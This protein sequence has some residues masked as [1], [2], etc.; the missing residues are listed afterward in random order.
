[1]STIKEEYEALRERRRKVMD[2]L[3]ILEEN[4][5]VKR[6]SELQK[7]NEELGDQQIR[8]YKDMKEE[9]YDSCSHILIYSKITDHWFKFPE[10][11][12]LGCIKCG[13]D[14]R[15]CDMYSSSFS[16]FPIDWMNQNPDIIDLEE[17]K[18]MYFYFLKENSKFTG[19][20]TGISCDIS[21]AQSIYSK[22]KQAHPNIDDETAIKYFEYALDKIRS[23]K[24]NDERKI[25]RAKRLSLTPNFKRWNAKDVHYH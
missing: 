5:P 12:S 4:E 10:H 6:Y 18:I 15:A 17:Y 22:I 11:K 25:S 23:T 13:L 2:D 14:S 19:T 8:L 1:M 3:Q 9:E 20:N 7:E 21:L 24:V 16:L